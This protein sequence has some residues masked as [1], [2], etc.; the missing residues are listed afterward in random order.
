MISDKL[1]HSLVIFYQEDGIRRMTPNSKDGPGIN[2]SEIPVRFLEMSC[3][4]AVRE[5]D[6]CF[7]GF[8]DAQFAAHCDLVM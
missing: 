1:V 5:Y 3:L 7:P 2:Q 6:R 8:V 4:D